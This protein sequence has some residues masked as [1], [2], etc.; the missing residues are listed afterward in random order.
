[1]LEM[2]ATGHPWVA[3]GTGFDFAPLILGILLLWGMRLGRVR[4]R[5][6]MIPISMLAGVILDDAAGAFGASTLAVITLILAVSCLASLGRRGGER[7]PPT[8]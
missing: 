1:M 3:G 5:A 2:L 7:L 6:W 4:V 8:V